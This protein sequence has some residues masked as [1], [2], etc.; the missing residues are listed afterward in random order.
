MNI[1]KR[2][3]VAA[4]ILLA[5][6]VIIMIIVAV[7]VISLGD[8]VGFQLSACAVLMV[9]FMWLGWLQPKLTGIGLTFLGL[10]VITIFGSLAT[11][12]SA[13]R[14]LGSPLLISGLLLLGAGWEFHQTT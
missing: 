14:L 10:F 2:L 5:I 6:T 7:K 1:T 8:Q 4:E 9:I 12:P 3:K 11:N 13:W